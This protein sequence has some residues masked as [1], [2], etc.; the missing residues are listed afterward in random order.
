MILSLKT[1]ARISMQL[2]IQWFP[3]LK[4][5]WSIKKKYYWNLVCYPRERVPKNNTS[6][7]Y[8]ENLPKGVS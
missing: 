1:I 8:V 5:V 4:L 7:I 3:N 6:K 2:G